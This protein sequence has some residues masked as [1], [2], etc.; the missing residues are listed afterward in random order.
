MATPTRH[1]LFD[2]LQQG[3]AQR[4]TDR[5][6]AIDNQFKAFEE[7]R[8]R[9]MFKPKYG[10]E[11]EALRHERAI[12]PSK[13]GREA[14]ALRHERERNP[15][16][17]DTM[18]EDLRHKKVYNP[19]L[20]DRMAE[21]IR[22]E[23]TKNPIVEGTL[24]EG[25]RHARAN[26]P[27][28]EA[29]AQEALRHEEAIH[30]TQEGQAAENLRHSM[31]LNPISESQ[32]E[33]VLRHAVTQNPLIEAG[34]HLENSQAQ[35]DL[36]FSRKR[37]PISLEGLAQ[38]VELAGRE[39]NTGRYY[40]PTMWKEKNELK[41]Q[42]IQ[43]GI[44]KQQHEYNEADIK[45]KM[46]DATI[47]YLTPEKIDAIGA[48]MGMEMEAGAEASKMNVEH[49]QR[50]RKFQ[51]QKET[52]YQQGLDQIHA[53]YAKDDW[54]DLDDDRSDYYEKVM[55]YI[56]AYGQQNPMQQAMQQMQFKG[57]SK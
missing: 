28:I 37:N 32:Q 7:Q 2:I 24:E 13:E 45:S 49:L 55:D 1:P 16:T 44:R 21:T 11:V 10:R 23:K 43:T 54:Y 46:T 6:R 30:P 33:E 26:N 34:K 36:W 38:K 47:K 50:Y 17:E 3:S 12:N 18:R 56:N 39:S 31:K 48:G 19:Q 25:L 53:K 42:A 5:Q 52:L 35:E 20:E 4:S 51:Q 14:E 9:D 8:T 40:D 57:G 22:H 15:I 41:E 29:R 27:I